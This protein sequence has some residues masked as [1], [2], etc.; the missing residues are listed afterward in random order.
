MKA[1]TDLCMDVKTLLRNDSRTK[2]GRNYLGLLKRDQ[3]YHYTFVETLPTTS[4][5][6]NLRVFD[7]KYVT[8]TQNSDGSLRPNIKPV[9]IDTDFNVNLYTRCLY[10]EL[11]KA[12]KTLMEEEQ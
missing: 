10:N 4:C 6:R 12:L 8:V 9:R 1:N 11:H 2:L 5:K 7:G 3:E